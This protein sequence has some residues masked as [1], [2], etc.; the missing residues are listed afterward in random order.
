MSRLAPERTRA[1]GRSEI[2]RQQVGQACLALL[3]AGNAEFGHLDVARASG[4]SRATLYRWWPT[5][6]ALLQEA[7]TLHTL[8]L[9]TPDTGSWPAD[10]REFTKRLARFFADPVE[11]SMNA[12]MASGEHPE[13]TLAVLAHYQPLFAAWRAMVERAQDR[14]EVAADLNADAVVTMLTSPLVN[15]PLLFRRQLSRKALAAHVDLVLRATQA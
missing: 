4:V 10:L 13:F 14:G 12:L 8:V 11:V 9:V 2:V 3:A 5:K 6:A 1:G 7:L 15:T